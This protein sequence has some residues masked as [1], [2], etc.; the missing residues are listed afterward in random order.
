MFRISHLLP[1]HSI[2]ISVTVLAATP[3]HILSCS[4]MCNGIVDK[5]RGN[6]M[7][8]LRYWAAVLSRDCLYSVL[9]VEHSKVVGHFDL[10]S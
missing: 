5:S 4:C 8:M 7:D 6:H 10:F 3:F 9:D 1:E 2:D